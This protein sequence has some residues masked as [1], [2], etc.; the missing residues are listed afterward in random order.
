MIKTKRGLKG[1]NRGG[2]EAYLAVVVLCPWGRK[3]HTRTLLNTF[4]GKRG[5]VRL[6]ST[7]VVVLNGHHLASDCDAVVELINDALAERVIIG[8]HQVTTDGLEVGQVYR[9]VELQI[10]WIVPSL[11]TNRR[12]V[13]RIGVYLGSC[14]AREMPEY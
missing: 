3:T 14:G 1:N 2:V 9:T 6:G 8:D 10:G 11:L 7:T 13:E 12:T 5:L 4:G